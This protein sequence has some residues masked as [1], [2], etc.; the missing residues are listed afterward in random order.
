MQKNTLINT[1]QQQQQRKEKKC[2]I[3]TL[4]F[5]TKTHRFGDIRLQKC[6]RDISLQKCCD[7][8]NQVRG[9]SR[10]LEMSPFDKAHMTS[11]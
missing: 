11:Y 10:S 8:E 3:E 9:P 5:V 7:L 6:F 4:S 1:T 2:S